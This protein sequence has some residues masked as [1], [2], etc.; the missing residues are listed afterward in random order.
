MDGSSDNNA[1][2]YPVMHG[3]NKQKPTGSS[4][5]Q[6]WWLNQLNLKILHQNSSAFDPMGEEFNYAE[7]FESLDL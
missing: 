5:N 7:E 3:A 6:D 4:A 2:K 1:C